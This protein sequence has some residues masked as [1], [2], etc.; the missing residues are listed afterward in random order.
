MSR[1]VV[2]LLVQFILLWRDCLCKE[3][4]I[5]ISN[6]SKVQ[7]S[8]VHCATL[9]Q[10]A[11][12]SSA[13][14]GPAANI[15]LVLEQGHHQ[16]DLEL[17]VS[18]VGVLQITS[19]NLTF[20][21]PR[22]SIKLA[23]FCNIGRLKISGVNITQS[24]GI[25]VESVGQLILEHSTFLESNGTALTL[26][27]T[28][29]SI[30]GS[31]FIFNSLGTYKGSLETVTYKNKE[32][33][34]EHVGGAVIVSETNVVI[35]N[36][37][38][39]GNNAEYGGAI[40]VEL[41]SQI[42]V[43]KSYFTGNKAMRRGGALYA[44]SGCHVTI[45]EN[46]YQNNRA[47]S[48]GGA[49]GFHNSTAFINH[50]NF[51]H[52]KANSF[53]GVISIESN[54]TLDITGSEFYYNAA[55]GDYNGGVMHTSKSKV[56]VIRSKFMNNNHSGIIR[57]RDSEITIISST[58]DKNIGGVVRTMRVNMHVRSSQFTRNTANESWYGGVM[59]LSTTNTSITNCTFN[60]NIA[61]K[62]GV[63]E[64]SVTNLTLTQCKFYRNYAFWGG[65]L[66]ALVG[67]FVT[68][69]GRNIMKNNS[70]YQG[71]VLFLQS[72][73]LL[74]GII[75]FI[76]NN[77]SIIAHHSTV[78]FK[79]SYFF[80]GNS[81]LKT[82]EITIYQ[83]GGA[84]TG[85][86]S[87]IFLDGKCII[88]NNHAENGGAIYVT[89]SKVNILGRIKL[90]NNSATGSGGGIYLYQS[91]LNCQKDSILELNGNNATRKGGGIHAISSQI[92]VNFNSTTQYIGSTIHF[93]GN[94]AT[95]GGGISLEMTSSFHILRDNTQL[96]S[97]STKSLYVVHFTDNQA[98]LGGAVYVADDTN[99]AT[100]ANILNRTYSTTECFLQ[101][102]ALRGKSTVMLSNIEFVQNR[103]KISGNSLFGGLLDRC[104]VS[105]FSE[106]YEE[107]ILHDEYKNL[108]GLPQG[109]AYLTLVSNIHDF[110]QISS[111]PVQLHYCTS[112]KPD[113]TYQGPHINIRAGE[114]FSIT[115]AAIDQVNHTVEATVRSSLASSAGGLG[116]GQLI[117]KNT[118]NCTNLTF[119]VFSINEEEE[120]IMYAEGPCKDASKSQ[121]RL[122]IKISACEC[123]TGFQRKHTNRATC[124]CECDSA[125]LPHITKCNPQ[126]KTL[127]RELNFWITYTSRGNIS[128]YVIHPNC[129]LD[130]CYPASANIEIN[131][132]IQGG[133]NAQ[134]EY[135]RSGKLC[136]TCKPGLS[137][138]LSSPRCLPCSRYWPIVFVVIVLAALLLG[139][140][141]VALL[142]ILN[143]TVAAGTLNGL[144][145]YAN[146]VNANSNIYFPYGQP[147]FIT[148][149]IAWLNL[150][151]GIDVCFFDGLDAYWKSWLQIAFPAYLVFLV[152]AVITMSKWSTK[153]SQFIG[154]RNPVATL[155]TLILLSYA[156]FLHIIIAALSF[157]ILHYPDGSREVVWLPDATIS[158]F[159]GKHSALFIA[160]LF[161]LIICTAY[162]ILIF[163]WQWL[164]YLQNKRYFRWL[165]RQKL[166]LFIEP[167]HIP[168]TPQHRYWTG[169]LLVVRIVLYLTSAVNVSGDPSISLLATGI[170]VSFLLFLKGYFGNIYRNWLIGSLEVG[171]Y[172]NI[173]LL[174]FIT[175]FLLNNDGHL[176]AATYISGLITL[177]LTLL[178]LA[179]HIFTE[180]IS[181]ARLW[182]G[183][184]G[185]LIHR[186]CDTNDKANLELTSTQSL[187]TST[188][189]DAPPRGGSVY[190]EYR[191]EL[192][193]PTQTETGNAFFTKSK[194]YKFD[195]NN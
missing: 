164:V 75:G 42:I 68:T 80:I 100:C 138:S 92:K 160:A 36:T 72:T 165:L 78:V 115:I 153:F 123:S 40:Y 46:N 121:L 58:F 62:G 150:D 5:T 162:T 1:S 95:Q 43:I 190:N 61:Y 173:V 127:T 104:T 172:L 31:Y 151:L 73:G 113:P 142:L 81:Q 194:S 89:Q 13:Y 18:N 38:F 108:I 27:N 168:Y 87:N 175:L 99:P 34:F 112:N 131:L 179:Y 51:S 147:K 111:E 178:V 158:Y 107:H 63:L 126:S 118:K 109:V 137:L 17:T 93:I 152:F 41:N 48:F 4:Y 33:V 181:K 186:H 184:E 182:H 71:I 156:K 3:F 70:G 54:S 98:D 53:G 139:I 84:I 52:N 176:L 155:A 96:L 122:P 97:I 49:L 2:L 37:S 195:S 85:F 11:A 9:A 177:A 191:E 50:S 187:L 163:S 79:R 65:V 47:G 94:K 105:P 26:I 143:L 56:I 188:I 74:S 60:D 32:R 102:L 59:W 117:Q 114:T 83:E 10:I 25:T 180:M 144:I 16:L 69:E 19:D 159:A 167:Y 86:Q 189:V 140:V 44:V 110:Q 35:Q 169:L 125:L 55:E 101:T 192:L 29:A 66:N 174:S 64:V 129:P 135:D 132:G 67:S 21:A 161:I 166:S 149:F 57:G 116:E 76:N 103:A 148:I 119:T 185:R 28:T 193:E 146:I 82:S 6:N 91:E 106:T 183:V 12:N 145:F 20:D 134:C 77:G 15:T 120:L 90:T 22:V 23:K 133:A 24:G 157:T 39:K 7:C 124:E 170:V 14:L 88:R 136:G 130:Y 45:T 171:C 30:V 154:K 128:G 141:L 8:V